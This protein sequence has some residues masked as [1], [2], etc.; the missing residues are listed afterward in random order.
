MFLNSPNELEL[1]PLNKI[2]ANT[3]DIITHTFEN[4][5]MNLH[6]SMTLKAVIKRTKMIIFKCFKLHIFKSSNIQ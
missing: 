3:K 1:L 4:S 6:Y 2:N 5:L